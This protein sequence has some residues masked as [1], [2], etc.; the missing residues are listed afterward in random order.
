MDVGDNAGCNSVTVVI[1]A[2][3]LVSF[4]S[5]QFLKYMEMSSGEIDCSCGFGF[6]GALYF[7]R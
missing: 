5:F 1:I 6:F 3:N 2:P 4:H 7:R